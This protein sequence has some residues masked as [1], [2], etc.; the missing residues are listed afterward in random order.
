MREQ[1]N[2]N[3]PWQSAKAKLVNDS[4]TALLIFALRGKYALLFN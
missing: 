1:N 3:Y 4:S 2:T